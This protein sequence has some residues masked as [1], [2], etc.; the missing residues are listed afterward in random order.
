MPCKRYEYSRCC[1]VL[2]TNSMHRWKLVDVKLSK[3]GNV[4]LESLRWTQRWKDTTA[5]P[6]ITQWEDS[7]SDKRVV[8]LVDGLLDSGVRVEVR[9]F[10]PLDDVDRLER[11]WYENG[12]KKGIKTSNYALVN[13]AAV[14]AA[15]EKHLTDVHS[16]MLTM[17]DK[18]FQQQTSETQRAS[19]QELL[20]DR[21]D[22]VWKTY[23]HARARRDDQRTDVEERDLLTKVLDLW[24]AVRLT[25]RSFW[26]TG[27][28]DLGIPKTKRGKI[29]LPP[30]MGQYLPF[31][32]SDDTTKY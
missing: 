5:M 12:Q 22:L 18:K 14:K 4:E 3:P 16:Q 26:I 28:E 2:Y 8:I 30:V 20:G 27:K 19:F 15:Y 7:S 10:K 9:R 29:L 21:E 31:P 1:F 13:V 25:T 11:T 24:V 32:T 23:R 17:D 6:E